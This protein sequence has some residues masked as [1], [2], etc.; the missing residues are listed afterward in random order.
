MINPLF[1]RYIAVLIS[2]LFASIGTGL[3]QGIA[4][5]GGLDALA[6]QPMGSDQG[7]RTMVIG[8]ALTE[9]GV[10]LTLV[11]VLILIFSN[12]PVNVAGGLAELGMGL[13]IG[14]SSAFVSFASSKIV[15]NACLAISRQPFF[16]NKI[17]TFMLIVQ[18]II[19]APVIFAFLIA[20]V[21][22]MK[23]VSDLSIY[24]GMIFLSAGILSGLSCIGTSIGQSLVGSQACNAIGLNRRGYNK[25]FP[26]S[27]ISQ[28]IIET[29]V[30][31]SL[32]LSILLIYKVPLKDN[33]FMTMMAAIAACISMGIGSIG[34]G[35]AIGKVASSACI[36]IAHKPEQYGMLLRTSLVSQ[37][38]IESTVIYALII[39]IS[40]IL[41]F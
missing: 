31:F 16:A 35:I 27:L 17:F 37:V 23:I 34:T 24:E 29:S 12:P 28:A 33:F 39:A 30:I 8:L 4:G 9:T 11:T 41:L 20:F 14:I 15:K 5:R 3:G 18:S 25:I 13:G 32:L 19:E 2:V 7:F 6:R 10:I 40:I 36:Q 22:N 26:F 21:I 38:L 1:L